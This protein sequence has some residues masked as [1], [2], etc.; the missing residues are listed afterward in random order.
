LS[1]KNYI[2]IFLLFLSTFIVA[3]DFEFKASVSKKKLGVNQRLKIE[4]LVN[5]NGAD[6]F[7][8]PNFTKFKIV[9]GPSSSVSQSWINGKTSYSH[10]YTYIIEPTAVG[11]FT[12]PSATIEY[13]GKIISSNTVSV[14]VTKKVAVPE[15]PNDPNYIAQEN[16]FLV[17]SLSKSNPYVGESVYVEYRLYFS[18]NVG[19][20]NAQFGDIPKYEGFWNQEIP[21]KGQ[22][23]KK[24]KLKGEDYRYYT[25]KKAILIPQKSGK[26]YIDPIKMDMI[27]SVPTGR[28][29]FFGNPQTR[30][31]SASY[32]SKRKL[33]N[34]KAL[35]ADGKPENFTGAVGD[36]DLL[37]NTN[38]NI[39][40]ANESTQI[41][42]K[43]SGKG[44]LKLFEI[45]KISV[46]AELEVYTPERKQKVSTT[47]TGLKGSIT[48]S[49]SIVPEYKGK[50]KI[51][52]V[53]F[54]YFNPKDKQYH[55]IVSDDIIID[56]TEGKTLVSTV[57]D[58]TVSKQV[59]QNTG[60]DF[61]FIQTETIFESP[62][63]T[64]FYKSQLFYGLI[65]TPLLAIPFGIFIGRKRK[66][67]L[68]DV[69]GNKIRTAD[70]L[71]KKY[72]SDAKKQLKNKEAFYIALEKALHNFLKAKLQIETSDISQDKIAELLN[73]NHVQNR[74]VE[75][76]ISVLN[77][78]DFARYAPTTNLMMKEEY[79]KAAKVIS[80]IN[81]ELK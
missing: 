59:I 65:I 32:T 77:D 62:K 31:V 37:V 19:F 16:I 70:K 35:P 71:A 22:A 48:D 5:K 33:V 56:V 49:Y 2:S 75:E 15:N 78:C 13:D 36:F 41:N 45:P 6:N 30:N 53:I 55:S 79:K 64:D 58:S 4:F 67:K 21:I 27:V 68:A 73:E 14:N 25:L 39:L 52:A 76:F 29:D 7:K 40:K 80:Q 54:S 50:Y 23:E 26:L 20:G 69:H 44:N 47:L 3:Q 1:V 42:V 38:K 46:P 81:T 61:R 60:G 43:I 72:L 74:T 10:T 34:V 63:T 12:I 66:K 11:T 51:P 24:G 57:T 9:A 18:S 8:A 17:A 28:Y